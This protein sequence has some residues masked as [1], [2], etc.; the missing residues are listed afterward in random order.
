MAEGTEPGAKST[1]MIADRRVSVCLAVRV[2]A[3]L[4]FSA[5]CDSSG[6][7]RHGSPESHLPW[8]AEVYADWLSGA[9]RTQAAWSGSVGQNV[10]RNRVPSS[11]ASGLAVQPMG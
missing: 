1:D 2:H 7:V 11:S 8:S 4:R 5:E 3:T 9:I 6:S 10:G